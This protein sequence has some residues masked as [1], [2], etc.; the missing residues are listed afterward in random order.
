MEVLN[1]FDEPRQMIK[2]IQLRKIKFFGYVMKYST[3]IINNIKGK[4]NWK[5]GKRQ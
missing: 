1:M 2:M 5:R 3:F 4:I